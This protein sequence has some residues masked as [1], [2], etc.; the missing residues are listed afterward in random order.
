VEHGVCSGFGKPADQARR[1][2]EYGEYSFDDERPYQCQAQR[3][4]S[5]AQQQSEPGAGHAIKVDEKRH[6]RGR[7]EHSRLAP[8]QWYVVCGQHSSQ[9]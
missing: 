7:A 6:G 1:V 5:V 3:G 9:N 8:V 4:G 2:D